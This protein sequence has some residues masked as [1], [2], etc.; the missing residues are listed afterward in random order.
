MATTKCTRHK[1]YKICKTVLTV[2]IIETCN[3]RDLELSYKNVTFETEALKNYKNRS[4]IVTTE[5]TKFI[6]K[7][8]QAL[9]SN[10][11]FASTSGIQPIG[12]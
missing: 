11:T 8:L 3:T 1:K 12:I 7:T 6:L 4:K 5:F 10:S 2:I 9:L